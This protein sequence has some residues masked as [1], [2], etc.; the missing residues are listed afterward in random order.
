MI[1]GADTVTVL[2]G[3]ARDNWGNR[4]GTDI[5]TDVPGCSVQPASSA[6]Q[7]SQGDL[8]VT[9]LSAF[10]P[11]G[12]DVLVTDRVQVGGQVYEVDGTPAR[13]RGL[14]G[15]EDHV[16]VQLKLIQGSD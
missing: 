3:A 16:Q 12:T 2:R 1:L 8:A 4:T 15:V 5:A 6:E 11:A 10:L 7:T 9:N 14:S 13:W